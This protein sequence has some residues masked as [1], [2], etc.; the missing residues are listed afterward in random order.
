M[1]EVKDEVM[2]WISELEISTNEKK[3]LR[4]II[5]QRRVG[6]IQIFDIK[7]GKQ[8]FEES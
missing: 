1:I 8:I 4:S 2:R 3:L 6:T 5:E 7:T